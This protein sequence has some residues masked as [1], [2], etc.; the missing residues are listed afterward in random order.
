[1]PLRCPVGAT[2]AAP[3]VSYTSS[4]T[5]HRI[6]LRICSSCRA[7]LSFRGLSTQSDRRRPTSLRYQLLA[8][9]LPSRSHRY[10]FQY[11]TKAVAHYATNASEPR[12]PRKVNEMLTPKLV[13]LGTPAQ[14]RSV[15]PLALDPVDKDQLDGLTRALQT[16]E[17]KVE[18]AEVSNE[19]LLFK[20]ESLRVSKLR[21]EQVLK[22]LDTA[23]LGPQV[24]DYLSTT[25]V[26]IAG[27][28]SKLRKAQA[29][30][31]VMR[32]VWGVQI[33]EEIAAEMDVIREKELK[34]ERMHLFFMMM[35]GGDMLQKLA[36]RN[37]TRIILNSKANTIILKGTKARIERVEHQLRDLPGRII[38]DEVDISAL[39]RV[40]NVTDTYIPSISRLTSVFLEI[41]DEKLTLHGLKPYGPRDILDAKRL[42]FNST[43]LHFRQMYSLLG[44]TKLD[45]PLTGALYP[46]AE[47]QTLPWMYRGREWCRWRGIRTPRSKTVESIE[48]NL[49]PTI[50]T[51]LLNPARGDKVGYNDIRSLLDSFST[52]TPS[53]L[54][55]ATDSTAKELDVSA[56]FGEPEPASSPKTTSTPPYIPPGAEIQTNYRAVLG[57]IL[58]SSPTLPKAR[59]PKS[60][61]DLFAS[62]PSHVL[63]NS[64]PKILD[65]LSTLNPVTY[66]YDFKILLK[67]SPSPW[68]H[69]ENFELLPPVEMELQIKPDTNE[70]QAL[71]VAAVESHSIVDVLMPRNACDLR[72]AKRTL[73]RVEGKTKQIKNYIRAA[74][75]DVLGED[76]LEAGEVLEFNLPKWMISDAEKV[77]P[78][79]EPSSAED[80][81]SELAFSEMYDDADPLET[82]PVNYFFTG[83]ETRS[84]TTFDFD[85][86]ALVYTKIEAGASGGSYDEV[87]LECSNQQIEYL[88]PLEQTTIGR[89][90]EIEEERI[91]QETMDQMME[92]EAEELE[93]VTRNMR[94]RDEYMHDM[95]GG[96]VFETVD[97]AELKRKKHEEKMERRAQRKAEKLESE[98]LEQG[99]EAAEDGLE[100]ST[101]VE[102]ETEPIDSGEAIESEATNGLEVANKL[103]AIV[104]S[105][106]TTEAASEEMTESEATKEPLK[107]FDLGET[108]SEESLQTDSENLDHELQTLGETGETQE[109][110]QTNKQPTGLEF[111]YGEE[112]EETTSEIEISQSQG[113]ESIKESLVGAAAEKQ[114]VDDEDAEAISDAVFQR[115]I[116]TARKLV[117]AVETTESDHERVTPKKL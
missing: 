110:L 87:V 1:M 26:D 67:F 29:L 37:R 28:V 60:L 80:E 16:F 5:S 117:E 103:E 95:Q 100:V 102:G 112:V 34:F 96:P 97:R 86:S 43:D 9:N 4:L 79:V 111:L 77:A 61:S 94:A 46:V 73:A 88:T 20:P 12:P 99:A 93:K 40:A 83:L 104:G 19:I 15:D 50:S 90:D 74:K 8:D 57:Q 25:E 30:N 21:F 56:I 59:E 31:L 58:H 41:R 98:K 33:D 76:R 32:Q 109:T 91:R 17:F 6:P 13:I 107:S 2:R 47:D 38:P 52:A 42:L 114:K 39:L 36:S 49:S 66:K 54:P 85:G 113:Q 53:E 18:E 63:C 55:A 24:K 65:F 7:R 48:D 82:V 75:L 72:F 71:K 115:F 10:G 101:A 23:F 22:D 116:H 92:L 84:S 51:P 108:G 105:E 44:E 81:Y 45:S 3:F 27:G 89:E 35:G 62:N 70:L 68:K 106:E 64:V 14:R 69:P 78:V 11:P